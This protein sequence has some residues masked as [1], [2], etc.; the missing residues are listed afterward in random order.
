MRVGGGT[1]KCF[2]P[3]CYMELCLFI[4]RLQCVRDINDVEDQIYLFY[5]SLLKPQQ[6]RLHVLVHEIIQKLPVR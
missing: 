3:H 6:S 1:A 5:R 4:S 2:W